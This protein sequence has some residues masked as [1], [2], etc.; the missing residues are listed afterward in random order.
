MNANGKKNKWENDGEFADLKENE[1]RD[2][3]GKEEEEFW[4]VTFAE[5]VALKEE[6]RKE[7]E[8]I[9]NE[10]NKEETILNASPVELNL[11][12]AAAQFNGANLTLLKTIESAIANSISL[13]PNTKTFLSENM[14]VH[15]CYFF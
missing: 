1:F 6:I 15:Y 14:Q 13:D 12:E 5:D 8:L 9:K 4:D 3:Q 10:N 2:K 11:K 7:I